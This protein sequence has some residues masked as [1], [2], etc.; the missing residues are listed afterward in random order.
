MTADSAP[1]PPADPSQVSNEELSI[2]LCGPDDRDEQARLFNACF[3]KTLAGDAL[4]WR[5][6]QSP[7]GSSVSIVARPP[8]GDA[9]CGYACSPRQALVRGDEATLA[10]VGQTGDVM[11]HPDWRKRGI[12]SG[13]DKR[14]MEE[15]ARLGW[16]AVFGL[17]NRRSAHIFLKIGWDQV[18]TVRP[19]T[20]YF[21]ADA[22]ARALRARE[23]RKY[24]LKLVWDRRGCAS[25]RKALR[26]QSQGYRV[27]RLERFPESVRELARAVEARFDFMV[28]RDAD[29]LN[30]R[31]VDT[32]AKLHQAW[33]VYDASGALA[34][35]AVVQQPDASG[36]GASRSTT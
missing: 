14:C 15:T 30:W 9:I 22:D 36:V 34:G 5:Y 8:V 32:T 7:H 24:A 3:K 25:R 23:G 21:R 13:L 33:G 11:T 10:P 28:R 16:P 35:Y 31:F 19:W 6:D 27:E 12:F 26:S 18:G 4:R 29:Y 17:P 20:F 1:P 2:D